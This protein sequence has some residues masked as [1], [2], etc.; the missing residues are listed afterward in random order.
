MSEQALAEVIARALFDADYQKQLLADPEG[1]L[2]AVG[3]EPKPE[4]VA[5][6]KQLD[7]QAMARATRKMEK[8]FFDSAGT[9]DA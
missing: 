1:T 8:G 2:R 6:I 9:K 3:I 7:P 5:K 4:W